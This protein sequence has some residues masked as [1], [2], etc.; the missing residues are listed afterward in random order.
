MVTYQRN[1]VNAI[2]KQIRLPDTYRGDNEEEKE[3][4]CPK[5]GGRM[6]IYRYENG[7]SIVRW[8]CY[9]FKFAKTEWETPC[10]NNI[11]Y[12]MTHDI[13]GKSILAVGHNFIPFDVRHVA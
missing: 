10:P 2:A 1:S 5:C 9:G 11:D 8:R 13:T 6:E 4:F 7:G 3:M 12:E